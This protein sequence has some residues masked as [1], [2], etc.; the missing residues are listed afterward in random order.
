MNMRMIAVIGV[1]VGLFSFAIAGAADK[2]AAD[3]NQAIPN[4][5]LTVP[6]EPQTRSYLG[7]SQS[8][9]QFNLSQINADV[10]IIEIFDRFCPKSQEFTPVINKLYQKIQGRSDLKKRI[11]LI[12]I[13]IK[14]DE[15]DINSF[16]ENFSISFPLFD[17]KGEAVFNALTG[18]Q[19]PCY[20]AARKTAAGSGVEVFYTRQETFFDEQLFLDTVIAKSGLKF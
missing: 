13:G 4:I 14:N 7:L 6:F 12:G 15:D 1:S 3:F 17:D 20:F 19:T 11:K 8:K 2:Q 10:V 9:G 18:I 5:K 16:R